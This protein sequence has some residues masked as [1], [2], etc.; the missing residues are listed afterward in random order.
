MGIAK[1]LLIIAVV[2]V[3][4]V[5]AGRWLLD[6]ARGDRREPTPQELAAIQAA[7]RSPQPVASTG[8]PAP[9][10]PLELRVAWGAMWED[11]SWVIGYAFAALCLFGDPSLL[12]TRWLAWPV[13]TIALALCAASASAV[14]T[15]WSQRL[16]VSPAGVES[17]QGDRLD[18]RLAWSEVRAVRQVD[19]LRTYSARQGSNSPT[20]T[21]VGKQRL[22]F[23][24]AAGQE[25]LSVVAP[26]RPDEDYQAF[27]D[28]VPAWTGAPLTRET[29]K[30]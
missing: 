17:W 7:Q 11:I 1:Y 14:H 2:V 4:A 20:T 23:L 21:A 5:L 9:S 3:L 18:K 22:L 19:T 13:A 27:L 24:D 10:G 26:M 15:L 16:V 29:R 30:P 12:W 28:A 25:L 6:M 8:R